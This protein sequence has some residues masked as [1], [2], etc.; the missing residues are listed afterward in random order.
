[1]GIFLFYSIDRKLTKIYNKSTRLL[2]D[3]SMSEILMIWGNVLDMTSMPLGEYDKAIEYSE[4]LTI[5][6][7]SKLLRYIKEKLAGFRY[8]TKSNPRTKGNVVSYIDSMGRLITQERGS[9]EDDSLTE[10]AIRKISTSAK[11]E[12]IISIEVVE[13][14]KN[15]K[16]ETVEQTRMFYPNEE[17]YKQAVDAPRIK[18]I[19]YFKDNKSYLRKTIERSLNEEE[20]K[21]RFDA[22]TIKLNCFAPD[23]VKNEI[24]NSKMIYTVDKLK[25][26][27]TIS[28]ELKPFGTH[29]QI[30]ETERTYIVSPDFNPETEEIKEYVGPTESEKDVVLYKSNEPKARI[31]EA[32]KITFS[33]GK[34]HN[35]SSLITN[36]PDSDGNYGGV[37]RGTCAL[38]DDKVLHA[39]GNKSLI[40]YQN[41]DKK[42]KYT[43]EGSEQKIEDGYGKIAAAEIRGSIINLK[44]DECENFEEIAKNIVEEFKNNW[45][46][47]LKTIVEYKT[48]N[49]EN[50]RLNI[51]EILASKETK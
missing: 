16:G 3:L 42:M 51:K 35:I 31:E 49:A 23:T 48:P 7:G 5:Y 10:H 30:N 17:E 41:E 13:K 25:T 47:N 32:E 20:M 18:E 29:L 19:T 34:I 12:A 50:K 39:T 43:I 28:D 11:T 27:D 4:S 37:G 15:E 21:K 45:N 8:G 2:C 44:L 40:I 38:Y 22:G 6:E 33:L 26:E 46:V 24:L 36:Y 14:K 9:K 1:M